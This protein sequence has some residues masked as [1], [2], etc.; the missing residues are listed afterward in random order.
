MLQLRIIGAP[1]KED[2]QNAE[3]FSRESHSKNKNVICFVVEDDQGKSIPLS[4]KIKKS[5]NTSGSIYLRDINVEV[6]SKSLLELSIPNEYKTAL[7]KK[8]KT[9][10]RVHILLNSSVKYKGTMT[11]V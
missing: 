7:R 4:A 5:E 9:I 11:F 6:E 1:R 2:L 8:K 10:A 3:R